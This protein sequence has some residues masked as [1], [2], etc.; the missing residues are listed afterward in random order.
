ML[1][2]GLPEEIH[3]AEDLARF[4]VHRDHFSSTAVKP[5]AFVP[6]RK[7]RETSVTRHGREPAESLWGLGELARGSR[8]L[9]GAALFKARDVRRAGLDVYAAEPPER[10]AAIREWPWIGEDPE[11]QKAKQKELA[12]ELARAAGAPVLSPAA[13]RA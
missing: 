8:T 13:T 5:A 12:L 11:L 3:D 9:Y 7:D 10:H 6:N 4:L 2:S 1:S